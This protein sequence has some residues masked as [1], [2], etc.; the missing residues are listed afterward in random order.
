MAKVTRLFPKA[1]SP[2]PRGRICEE[3]RAWD[4]PGDGGW[5]QCKCDFCLYALKR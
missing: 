3:T 5:E 1:L 2:R 4:A